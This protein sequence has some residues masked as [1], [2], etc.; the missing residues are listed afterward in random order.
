MWNQP[1]V[2]VVLSGM[3][4]MKQVEENI[5]SA[6]T[7][8][9]HSLGRKELQLIKRVQKEYEKRTAI[10]CTK[11]G[12]C[13]PCPNGVNIRRNFELYN[14]CFI[15]DD[16]KPARRWYTLLFNEKERANMC[17][18]CKTCEE[19]CPQKILISEWMP[20]VHALLGGDNPIEK[21]DTVG[22]RKS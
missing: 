15:F 14:D 1:E 13:M 22:A 6:S 10:P 16:P 5:H 9:V 2:S 8:R 21:L 17:I 20:K 11:C 4:T 12:Y 19:K 18:Q 7:S 3:S